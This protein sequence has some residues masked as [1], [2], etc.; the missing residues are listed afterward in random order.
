MIAGDK[1][2]PRYGTAAR[3]ITRK[4]SG[5]F[6]QSFDVFYVARIDPGQQKLFF[7]KKQ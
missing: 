6:W 1:P 3:T 2:A 7:V 5:T 4:L